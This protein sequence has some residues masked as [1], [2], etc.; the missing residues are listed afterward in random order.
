MRAVT[1][2]RRRV[3]A[4]AEADDIEELVGATIDFNLAI[5]VSREAELEYQVLLVVY[6]L[7]YP[8]L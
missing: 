3:D 7:G 5:A 4:A 6:I 2:A 1:A 8:I